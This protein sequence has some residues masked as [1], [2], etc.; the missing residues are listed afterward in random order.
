M[1]NGE[2]TI[3]FSEREGFREDQFNHIWTQELDNVFSDV[4]K[5][6][7]RANHVA[8]FGLWRWL[9]GSFIS[10]I[11]LQ[12]GQKILDVCAGTNTIGIECL[13]REPDL[14]IYAID[15]SK[16]MQEVGR[17]T[18]AEQG[19]HIEGV[20]GDVHRLPYP[21]NYFDTVTLSYASRHL[22]IMDVFGE[23]KRVLKPGGHFYH[24]DMLR[25]GNKIIERLYYWYLQL[26]LTVTAWIFQSS[27]SALACRR[28]FVNA[29]RSFYSA[30]ELSS[31]LTYLGYQDVSSKTVLAGMV[32]FHKAVKPG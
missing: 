25:P 15:R 32:G 3:E 27:P 24:C 13:K 1:G 31:L 11:E 22:R 9:R 20:I 8:S 5:Y 23:I 17:T 14:K 10:T 19:L 4:A 29:I 21:D 26:C 16:A 7:E 12:A 6:Y 2:Q 30:K 28:Y 18:A